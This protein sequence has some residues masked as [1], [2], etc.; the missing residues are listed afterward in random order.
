MARRI[1]LWC[2]EIP[3]INCYDDGCPF[4]V[5]GCFQ[6]H[7]LICIGVV[8]LD[9]GPILGGTLSA[10]SVLLNERSNEKIESLRFDVSP[11][12]GR[13]KMQ[14][15]RRLISCR[16][17]ASTFPLDLAVVRF[18]LGNHRIKQNTVQTNVTSLACVDHEVL[19]APSKR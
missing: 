7:T 13:T 12:D 18:L 19:L 6:V 4:L 8:I 11:T 1:I 17:P 16:I 5:T 14:M 9:T 2:N 3:A 15:K 10:P